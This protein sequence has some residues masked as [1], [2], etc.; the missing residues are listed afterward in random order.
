MKPP[1]MPM[2]ADSAPTAKPIATGGITLIYSRDWRKRI[3]K[4]SAWDP[5]A[6]D[7]AAADGDAACARP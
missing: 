7:R 2:M 3:L 5:A 4:G 1:P 6:M